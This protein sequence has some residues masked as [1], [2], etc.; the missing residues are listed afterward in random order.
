MAVASCTICTVGRVAEAMVI[1]PP[2]G[3]RELRLH[4]GVSTRKFV[5][6]SVTCEKVIRDGENKLQ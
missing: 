3:D 5:S 1:E 4:V 2:H 6:Q